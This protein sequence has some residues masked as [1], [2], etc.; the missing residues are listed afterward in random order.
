MSFHREDHTVTISGGGGSFTTDHPWRGLLWNVLV[1][2]TTLSNT[3]LLIV[4]DRL[5]DEVIRFDQTA[6]STDNRVNSALEMPVLG[7]YTFTFSSVAT[8]EDIRVRTACRD[9]VNYGGR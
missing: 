7:R 9:T 3:Y 5:G 2:P 8:D 1:D 4:T 6:A